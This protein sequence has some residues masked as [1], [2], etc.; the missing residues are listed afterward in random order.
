MND[1]RTAKR[2]STTLFRRRIRRNTRCL[3]V[4]VLLAPIA[5]L[6]WSISSSQR[7]KLLVVILTAQ[8]LESFSRLF[9]SLLRAQ[10]GG[11]VVDMLIHVDGVDEDQ[12]LRE[13]TV[14]FAQSKVWPHGEK[15]VTIEKE[16]IGLRRSWLRVSPRRAHSHV[17]IFE[18]DMEVSSQFYNFFK[19]VHASNYF[20]RGAAVCLHPSDWELKV[21]AERQCELSET[22]DVRFYFTPEPC[23]WGPIWSSTEWHRFKRWAHNLETNGIQP[24]TPTEIGFNYNEYL[25]MDKDVQSPWVWRYNWE[26]SQVQLRYTM[27]CVG[28]PHARKYHMAVNHREPGNNF[29]FQAT[30]EYHDHLT[31]L[32]T[33]APLV[34]STEMN[35]MYQPVEFK[36]YNELRPLLPLPSNT[37][38][39]K[40]LFDG[41][42]VA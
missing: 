19:Y 11:M 41:T 15:I 30:Q 8:R 21:I 9:H 1:Q 7:I 2:V 25:K 20:S 12:S 24:F 23:N 37:S 42:T 5:T 18:D 3:L 33:L 6:R 32:L 17:A 13:R 36:G 31:S 22:P 16:K 40:A 29:I 35:S 10:Y 38:G 28:G 34:N 39:E 27:T 14:K 26:S 4:C